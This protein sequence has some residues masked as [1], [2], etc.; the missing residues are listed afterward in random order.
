MPLLSRYFL[1]P[2]L[3]PAQL[4]LAPIRMDYYWFQMCCALLHKHAFVWKEST[5]MPFAL[6]C[7]WHTSAGKLLSCLLQATE[8]LSA[9]G[10]LL[11]S[12]TI[13]AMCTPAYSP[14]TTHVSLMTLPRFDLNY[15]F[16]PPML[17]PG[18]LNVC[19]GENGD[20]FHD[21]CSSWVSRQWCS[22]WHQTP[23][24]GDMIS[25][26]EGLLQQQCLQT[27][28]LNVSVLSATWWKPV[29]LTQETW[30]L[31]LVLPLSGWE[32]S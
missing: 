21:F 8:M 15:L 22:A 20:Q 10:N 17:S 23:K 31:L 19:G 29:R 18:A 16:S 32:M 24:V 13:V 3:L 5:R 28:L 27:L 1:K 6:F 11:G 4:T 30:A 7:A 26:L 12:Q 14:H 2:H 9:L 25:S